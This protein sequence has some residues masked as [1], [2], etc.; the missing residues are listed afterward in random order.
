MSNP[1]SDNTK[2]GNQSCPN[3]GHANRPG[4]LV[5]ENCGTNLLTGEKPRI[6]THSF[7][8][9]DSSQAGG[10]QPDSEVVKSLEEEDLRAVTSAGTGTFSPAMILRMEIE[11]APTPIFISPTNETIFGRRDP[12]TGAMPDVD[13]TPY[14][15]YRMG[16]SRNH[17]A[18]QL[19]GDRIDVCDLG[20][21]NGTF[22]N[23]KRLDAHQ[24]QQL[25]DGDVITMGKLVFRVFFQHNTGDK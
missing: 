2:T 17:A 15:G 18:L 25:H 20:S 12:Q 22:L 10:K 9:S 7:Y 21:S 3:C 13:L 24:P 4:I 11:G 23:G 19:R 8:T 14:M 6:S 5:C 1:Q 16:I